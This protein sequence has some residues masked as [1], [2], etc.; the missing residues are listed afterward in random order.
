[1]G[2]NGRFMIDIEFGCT[3]RGLVVHEK[4]ILVNVYCSSYERYISE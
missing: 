3:N 1:L 4:I 2:E